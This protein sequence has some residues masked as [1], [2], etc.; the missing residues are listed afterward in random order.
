[1]EASTPSD[2]ALE[3]STKDAGPGSDCT[4]SVL[5]SEEI[6]PGELYRLPPTGETEIESIDWDGRY[7]VYAEYRCPYPDA[8]KFDIYTFDLNA[9]EE[10]EAV[11]KLASQR[12]V[13]I[14]EG[15][16]VYTDYWYNHPEVQG[17]EYRAEL[18]HLDPSTL[19]ET[20]LTDSNWS[21][22]MPKYNGSHVAYLSRQ[23]KPDG[24]VFDFILRDVSTNQ[25][26]I[27]ADHT[28]NVQLSY[29]ISEEYVSWQ[30]VPLDEPE[31]WDI[32]YHH[33]PSGVTERLHKSTEYLL[34]ALVSDKWLVFGDATS[35]NWDVHAYDIQFGVEHQVTNE[36][37][38]QVTL[39]V[40]GHLVDSFDYRHSGGSFPG[41]NYDLY[42][43]DLETGVSRRL[44][45]ESR[46]WGILRPSCKWLV[47]SEHVEA[48]LFRLFA[49]DLVAAGVLDE[50]CHLI[51]C[52][53]QTETCAMIEWRG[54]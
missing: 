3:A 25:E 52:D 16:V 8:R 6:V 30:A 24:G 51:P 32:F 35:G 50:N 18:V 54:M 9:M 7:V 42:L 14:W 48:N 36:E 46:Y 38:D 44:T 34:C 22:L 1:M 28:Q 5:P 37:H 26:Q 12:G 15:G 4:V 39:H 19:Q 2:G 31:V 47:Y 21:K 49:W 53:P 13:S 11:T 33:I 10:I 45:S 17:D 27:L 43:H 29:D 41:S 40:G 23:W 20:R